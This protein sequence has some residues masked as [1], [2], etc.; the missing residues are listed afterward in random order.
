M[1]LSKHCIRYEQKV[2]KKGGGREEQQG[3]ARKQCLKSQKCR[4]KVKIAKSQA[5]S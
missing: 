3:M 5:G 4:D 2:Y 1:D